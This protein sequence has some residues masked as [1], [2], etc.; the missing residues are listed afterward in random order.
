VSP[1]DESAG[2]AAASADGADADPAD[3]TARRAERLLR[4][5][6]RPWRDRYGAE[7]AELLVSEIAERPRSPR[8]SLDVARGG[9]RARLAEAGLAGFP[10]PA[11]TVGGG[12]GA[13][14]LAEQVR[15]R[16]V[17]ASLGAFSCALGAFLIF[18]AALWSQIL[19]NWQEFAKIDAVLPA[20]SVPYRLDR[21][22]ADGAF[23]A[24]FSNVAMLA[25][26]FLAVLAA[27]PVLA[28]VVGRIARDRPSKLIG[29]AVVLA[30]AVA[31]LFAGGRHFE[32]DWVGTGGHHAL[33]P[34]GLAAFIWVLTLFVSSWWAH[35][36]LF[37]SL[38]ATE[39]AWMAL[40]PFVLALAVASSAVLVRRVRLSPRVAAFEARLGLLG[41][42]TMAA[43]VGCYGIWTIEKVR[44][45]PGLPLGL[46]VGVT[47]ATIIALLIL[48]LAV[49]AQAARMA[50]RAARGAR[51]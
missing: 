19:I 15:Q 14:V 21:Q 12:G 42:V 44:V 2:P 37:A 48:A 32:N 4:W 16:Q 51:A 34:S 17:S 27:L 46:T 26:L 1:A 33:I 22:P 20:G 29:P 38:P 13:G 40:S 9:V 41:C 5:Y 36:L 50:F 11:A 28:A 23:Y 35:P 24:V 30:A 10:L 18:A 25:L 31:F 6:P 49:A 47:H 45:E 7:F 8:R 3:G 39:R 43:F